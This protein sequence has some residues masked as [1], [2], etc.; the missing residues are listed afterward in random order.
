MYKAD[1]DSLKLTSKQSQCLDLVV[2]GLT[3]VEIARTV[4]VK[5]ETVN[6]WKNH[7]LAFRKAVESRC[8]RLAVEAYFEQMEEDLE[9]LAEAFVKYLPKK[10]CRPALSYIKLL[11]VLLK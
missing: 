10:Y 4:G 11:H 8:K 1:L 7:N 5:R 9:L 3:D 2:E 6:R